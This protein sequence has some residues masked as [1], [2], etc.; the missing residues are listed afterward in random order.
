MLILWVV[1][2]QR[3]ILIPRERN[4]SQSVSLDHPEAISENKGT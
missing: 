2:T 1:H 3:T 4:L